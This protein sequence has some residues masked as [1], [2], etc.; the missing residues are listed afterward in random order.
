MVLQRNIDKEEILSLLA[1]KDG[2]VDVGFVDL[3]IA[4][5]LLDGIKSSKEQI[6]AQLLDTLEE[7][8]N[9]NG[10][11]SRGRRCALGALAGGPEATESAG[12]EERSRINQ[13]GHALQTIMTYLSV[14]AQ[15]DRWSISQNKICVLKGERYAQAGYAKINTDCFGMEGWRG[16]G[17]VCNRVS[18]YDAL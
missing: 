7:R 13:G 8:V 6:L 9:F 15:L 1:G 3:W 4:Q 16:R 14:H 10:S 18:R 2:L 17:I 12:I 5:G 11:L